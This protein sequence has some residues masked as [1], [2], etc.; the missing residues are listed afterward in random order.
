M[1][2]IRETVVRPP[3]VGVATVLGIILLIL[4][5]NLPQFGIC[6]SFPEFSPNSSYQQA[7]NDEAVFEN[8][9]C[10]IYSNDYSTWTTLT[11]GKLEYLRVPSI[12]QG[13][14]FLA[15][16][17]VYDR[18]GIDA[19]WI[20]GERQSDGLI[21]NETFTWMHGNDTYLEPEY[22]APEVTNNS[23]YGGF[24]AMA[25]ESGEP[26]NLRF[27][28]NDTNG[29]VS[30]SAEY[31]ILVCVTF[32][33]TT[34]EPPT[35]NTTDSSVTQVNLGWVAIGGVGIGTVVVVIVLWQRRRAP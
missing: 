21:V 17:D 3:G 7:G 35:T 4:A 33:L 10:V 32:P 2:S 24:N 18:D 19:V 25:L 14:W 31:R 29:E 12:S 9:T 8:V 22:G 13:Y 20:V 26:W 15:V 30:M 11:P 16:V 28:S 1:R 34:V 6:S 27:Y 23:Y 5:L